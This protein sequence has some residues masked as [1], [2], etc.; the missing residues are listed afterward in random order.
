MMTEPIKKLAGKYQGEI[1]WIIGCG[2]SLQY[3][4]ASLIGS[5]PMI[6]LNHSIVK[7]EQLGLTNPVYSMQ[8]DEYH[9][10]PK[11]A[12][13]IIHKPESAEVLP[14][15]E[16]R[17][18]FDNES[19]FGLPWNT[20]S[21][22]SATNI[23]RL[24]G[25]VKVV[26][27]SHDGCVSQCNDEWRP[28]GIQPNKIPK[29]YAHQGQMQREYLSKLTDIQ[30]EFVTPSLYQ[31]NK[32]TKLEEDNVLVACPTY[33]GKEYS[34]DA[35]VS[36][37][38]NFAYP[39]KGLFMVDNTGHDLKYYEHLQ[40]LGIP[41]DHI[42]MDRDWQKT[43]AMSWKRILRAAKEG[44]YRW[45]ASIEADNICPPLT[46]DIMLN[47]AGFARAVHVAHSYLWHQITIEHHLKEID[48]SR[49][50]GLGC[51]LFLT[52]L[53]EEVFAQEAWE[54]EAFEAE[55]YEYPKRKGMTCL[56]I[57]NLIDVR[58]LDAPRGAEFYQFAKEDIPRLAVV[59]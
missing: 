56:E 37:Y 35:Y 45:V 30:Y 7:V 53:L 24:M 40:S 48:T 51:N 36:A 5:G 18:I 14:D 46:L 33:R 20:F 26:F 15:Y 27:I 39:Y 32:V 10:V 42:P 3:L 4:T 28:T 57:H 58:H 31:S 47:V 1:C 8:K 41:C 13:L 21:A 52:D 11:G 34:L 22:I 16:P 38:N 59:K 19:D 50:I 9:S 23:A 6:A 49:L 43:F 29:I 44:G 55:I 25:C 54:T 17:F 12:A 2:P